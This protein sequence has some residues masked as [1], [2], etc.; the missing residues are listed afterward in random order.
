MNEEFFPPKE[1]FIN[2]FTDEG[3]KRIFGNEINKDMI[4]RFL[5]SLLNE[6]IT[7]ITFRNVEALGICRNDRK[8]V[9]DIFCETDKHELIIV[10]MQKSSQKYFS[11]RVLYYA[12]FAIQQQ[13]TYAKEQ[14]EQELKLLKEEQEGNSSKPKRLRWNYAVNRVYV[15]CFLN[16]IMDRKHPAK[17]RWDIIRMDREL[18][19]PFSDTL[20]E[21]YL[22]MPKFNLRLSECDT[23]YKKFLFA[24]NNIEIMERL[25]KELN[26]QIFQKLKSIV[27]IERMTPDERLAYELSLSTERDLYACMETKYEEGLEKGIEKGKAEGLA[28]GIKSVAAR[29]KHLGMD[30]PSITHATGLTEAEIQAL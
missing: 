4:I 9:F 1:K 6:T 10:E 21:I 20:M 7:D 30:L 14:L 2:P 23:L 27:E 29:L 15:V 26:E 13:A 8:A 3:F 18:K 5:N 24:L 22:E 17:Y 16:Y 19:E 25:P 28:E 11:D 12:S